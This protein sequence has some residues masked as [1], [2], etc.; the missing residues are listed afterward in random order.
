MHGFS[1]LPSP[2]LSK[3][4]FGGNNLCALP[5][6]VLG[7]S[8]SLVFLAEREDISSF[9][10]FVGGASLDTW[11]FLLVASAC[12]LVWPWGRLKYVLRGRSESGLQ[13][14]AM[15]RARSCGLRQKPGQHVEVELLLSY[16]RAAAAPLPGPGAAAAR[17]PA[18]A[19]KPRTPQK[20]EEAARRP[21]GGVSLSRHAGLLSIS[22]TH[23]RLT[24][25]R[26]LSLAPNV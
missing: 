16:C 9:L 4:L 10:R 2:V 25:S 3:Y 24:L 12:R 19:K 22:V 7:V 13:A 11:C 18:G 21:P 5:L 14:V 20:P 1:C 15:A 17:T 8:L 23:T 26:E 6:N